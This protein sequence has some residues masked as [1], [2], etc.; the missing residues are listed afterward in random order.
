[1]E[2]SDSDSLEETRP[3]EEIKKEINSLKEEIGALVANKKGLWEE[4][5]AFKTQIRTLRQSE[6]TRDEILNI[7]EQ[8]CAKRRAVRVLHVQI[9]NSK[10]RIWKLKSALVMKSDV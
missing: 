9:T 7:R 8:L 6:G 10:R 1:M 5:V 3:V 4:L 2:H